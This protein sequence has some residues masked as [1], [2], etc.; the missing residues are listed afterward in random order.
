MA[1]ELLVDTKP[2]VEIPLPKGL[3]DSL[4]SIPAVLPVP[5]PPPPPM[6]RPQERRSS[7]GLVKEVTIPLNLTAEEVRLHRK[8]RLKITLDI[9]II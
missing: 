4:P 6:S 7:D 2:S 5:P 9:T 3:V 1:T 8:L